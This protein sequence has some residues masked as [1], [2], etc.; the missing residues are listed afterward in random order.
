MNV[1]KSDSDFVYQD[2]IQRLEKLVAQL[3]LNKN[4]SHENFSIKLF[5][6][7]F[8]KAEDLTKLLSRVLKFSLGVCI[9]TLIQIGGGVEWLLEKLR[10]QPP[11]TASGFTGQSAPVEARRLGS[12][13]GSQLMFSQTLIERLAYLNAESFK[14]SQPKS[15]LMLLSYP[16]LFH[17]W[18]STVAI[19]DRGRSSEMQSPRR[20]LAL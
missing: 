15:P 18:E 8:L 14:L 19:K 9:Q 2:R 4:S 6:I 20:S 5:G 12:G 11:A 13:T 10:F 3:Y 1:S 16:T 7:D 17:S